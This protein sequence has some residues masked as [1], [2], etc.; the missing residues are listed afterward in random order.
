MLSINHISQSFKD[1]KVLNDVNLKIN[2]GEIVCLYG[3]SGEGKSTIA[4]IMTG[5]LKPDEGQV[6]LNNKELWGKTYDRNEGKRIQMVAQDPVVSL[7]PSLKIRTQINELLRYYKRERD[8]TPLLVSLGLKEELLDHYPYQISGGEAQRINL[9]RAL[10]MEPSVL[11]LDEATSMCDTLNQRFIMDY[12][13][14]EYLKKS[15]QPTCILMISH[16]K[17]LVKDYA[18][19][20]YIIKGGHCDEKHVKEF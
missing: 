5:L 6:L 8:I 9:L 14:H 11:I 19:R 12:C 15:I 4:R 20:I 10:L 3:D 18:Q 1:K 2:D 16:N 17:E 7:D 13:V